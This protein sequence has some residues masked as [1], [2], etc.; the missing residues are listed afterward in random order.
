M[1]NA[2]LNFNEVVLVDPHNNDIGTM[3]KLEAHE[4]GLLHRAFSIFLFNEKGEMLVQKRAN[5]KYHSAG[6]WSNTCCSH[7]ALN[8]TVEDAAKR[9]LKEEIYLDA[10]V[11]TIFSFLYNEQL[12]DNLIEHELDHVLIGFCNSFGEINPDEVSEL[13]FID[14]KTLQQ[15]I[16]QSPQ[17]YTVWFNII[18]NNHWDKFIPHLK[19]K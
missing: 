10:E 1:S 17:N 7:P 9:R 5:S 3:E 14:V 4:K 16:K 11:K 13:K 12:T 15:D 19:L 6:L 8:E 18:M 2:P